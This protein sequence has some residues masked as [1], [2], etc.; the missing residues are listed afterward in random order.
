MPM[1]IIMAVVLVVYFET[2]K[3]WL[4]LYLD[5]PD[6]FGILLEESHTFGGFSYGL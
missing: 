3:G 1:I 6:V 5:T 2:S 4:F